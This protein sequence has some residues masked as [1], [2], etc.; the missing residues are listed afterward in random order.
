MYRINDRLDAL[1]ERVAALENRTQSVERPVRVNAA[2]MFDAL[3][4][5]DLPK[6]THHFIQSL[7]YFYEEN[8]FLTDNQFHCLRRNYNKY[9]NNQP[10]YVGEYNGV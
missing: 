6:S 10:F 8:G 1:E 7:W 5:A 3:H 4:A 2:G 9:I